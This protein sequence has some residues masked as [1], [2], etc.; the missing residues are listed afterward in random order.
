MTTSNAPMTEAA[1]RAQLWG[2]A[3]PHEPP[4]AGP[5][6]QIDDLTLAKLRLMELRRPPSNQVSS[7]IRN[8]LPWAVAALAVGALLSRSKAA[9]AAAAWIGARAARQMFKQ[10]TRQWAARSAHRHNGRHTGSR[11]MAWMKS[12]S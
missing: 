3:N 12:R 1:I 7:L 6:H 5:L 9:R 10:T 4:P 8:P 2:G 11:L